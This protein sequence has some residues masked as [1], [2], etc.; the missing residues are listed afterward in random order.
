MTETGDG[1]DARTG[2]YWPPDAWF[3]AGPDL[4]QVTASL[5]PRALDPGSSTTDEPPGLR[6]LTRPPSWR[7]AS[8]PASVFAAQYASAARHAQTVLAVPP[9][10]PE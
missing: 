10:A 3:D 1:S 6:A 8:A 5:E 4:A 7:A 2:E 9:A